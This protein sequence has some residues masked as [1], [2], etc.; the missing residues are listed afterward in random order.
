MG[1][2][3]NIECGQIAS[4][5]LNMTVKSMDVLPFLDTLIIIIG[6]ENAF[7][8]QVNSCSSIV[9]SFEII[10]RIEF[11]NSFLIMSLLDKFSFINFFTRFNKKSI[12]CMSLNF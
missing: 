3:G 2:G 5:E 11:R 12:L 4:Y 6:T 10:I 8:I 9:S 1:T 7:I